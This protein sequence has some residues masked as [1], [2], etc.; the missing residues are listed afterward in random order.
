[1]IYLTADSQAPEI[2][3]RIQSTTQ[4][5]PTNPGVPPE[6]IASCL[7][8]CSWASIGDTVASAYAHQLLRGLERGFSLDVL[9]YLAGKGLWKNTLP[10]EQLFYEDKLYRSLQK[11]NSPFI[12]FLA[13]HKNRYQGWRTGSGTR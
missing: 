10:D 13:G 5:F 1:M 9:A 2:A 11:T 12:P 7:C 3:A 4:L 6:R 8:W